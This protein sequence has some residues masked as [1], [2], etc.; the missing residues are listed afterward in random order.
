MGNKSRWFKSLFTNNWGL[1]LLAIILAMI[2]FQAVREVT[3]QTVRYDVDLHVNVEPGV[4]VHSQD[5]QTV[6]VM[7]RGSEEDLRRLEREKLTITITPKEINYEG[8]E[9]R[10]PILPKNV[11]SVPGV[12]VIKMEPAFARLQFD[13]EIESP[14]RI[15][16][17]RIIG[18]PAVG[19][20][21]ITYE[22]EAVVIRGPKR[23]MEDRKFVEVYTE[24]IDVSGRVRSFT[25]WIRVIP[26]REWVSQVDPAEISVKVKLVTE[27]VSK[28]FTN[29]TIAAF[30]K[31]GD[32]KDIFFEPSRVNVALHGRTE[33]LDGIAA[34]SVRVFVDCIDLTVPA[35]Y[36]LPV[37]IHLTPGTNARYDVEPKTVKVIIKER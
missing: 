24:P 30:T 37:N 19:K 8:I 18:S 20:A 6:Q 35:T 2:C 34:S 10:V 5:P 31:T 17:P 9:E 16:P 3:S 36:E 28:V 27:S 22:P 21:E 23:R 14:M 4:A 7:F 26:P 1:K 29:M 12:R 32:N 15:A 33:V 11:Q 13:R 25:K